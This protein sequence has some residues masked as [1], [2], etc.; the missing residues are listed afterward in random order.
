MKQTIMRLVQNDRIYPAEKKLDGENSKLL[1]IPSKKCCYV[2]E[3][4]VF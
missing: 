2:F 4:A 3:I 1:V